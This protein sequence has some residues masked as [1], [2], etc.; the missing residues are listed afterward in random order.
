MFDQLLGIRALVLQLQEQAKAQ[1]Q[2]Q[3]QLAAAA[4]AATAAEQAAAAAVTAAEQA[5]QPVG[6]QRRRSSTGGDG[7]R[8][9]S[10]RVSRANVPVFP[11]L[12]DQAGFAGPSS[13]ITPGKRC[14]PTVHAMLPALKPCNPQFLVLIQA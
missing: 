2:L 11:V 14:C 5:A 8:V 12:A 9:Q 4:A 3:Q 13:S 1:Q 10:R 7:G 6:V